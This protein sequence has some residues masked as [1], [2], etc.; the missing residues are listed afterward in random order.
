[1]QNSPVSP[2]S[3]SAVSLEGVVK[4]YRQQTV[5]QELSL[6][7]RRGEFLTLLGPS[8]CGKT[9][10]LN[11]IAGFAQADNGEIF[12]EDQLVTDLP[13]YQRQIGMVFQN[14]ALFPHM[15]VAR[16]IGYGLRMRRMPADEIAQR[17]AEAMALVKLDGLG[18]RKPRE[19][20]G[21]Q[22]Q[23]VALARALVIR[24]KVLLLDEP[25]SAL[26]KGLRGSMQVE[27]R[28]IQRKLGVTTVF[29]THDQGEALA[30]SDRI[31]VMSS[32]VIRQIATP[33]ELYRNPQAPFVASFLGDVNILPAHYH[34]SDPDGILL[35]L[36]AGLI[37]VARDR[38]VGGSHEGR[39]LDIYVRPEQIRLES[40]H[41]ESVLSGTVVNHVFQG[42]HIDSY[43][44]VDIPV[45]GHQRVMVR[46]AGLDALQ[47]WP[48][49]SVTG[50]ALPGQGISVFNVS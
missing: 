16:N 43:I 34:G 1:M 49:G 39:R 29:V 42:D 28:E 18:E 26:D 17:V 23:R 4:K 45:A 19:L 6:K 8:G 5:L 46:S 25:F 10:L 21:G 2:K 44:D 38:L 12:I 41:S 36:G 7:I 9:T 35:R 24:P 50:L 27:I 3:S 33:D 15:T 48:V 14:Y 47:H 31:A 37:R 40:L 11:L 20:S 13:P 30:M 32:G 22:Q